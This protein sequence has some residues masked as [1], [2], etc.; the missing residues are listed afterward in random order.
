MDSKKYPKT[1]SGREPGE[2]SVNEK[3]IIAMDPEDP[4]LHGLPQSVESFNVNF[5]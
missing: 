2:L 3:H 5:G 4:T 1:D